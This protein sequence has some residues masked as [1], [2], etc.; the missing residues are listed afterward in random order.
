MLKKFVK[1]TVVAA[2]AAAFAGAAYAQSYVTAGGTPVRS[3]DGACWRTANWTPDAASEECDPQLVAKAPAPLLVPVVQP[4]PAAAG[5][6][7]VKPAAVKMVP[8]TYTTEVLFAFNDDRLGDDALVRLDEL[9]KQ[10]GAVDIEKI[11]AIGYAD[12]IG[13][14]HYNHLLSARRLWAVRDYLAKKGITEEQMTLQAKGDS[15]PVVS[16]GCKFMWVEPGSSRE[17]I[18]CM[19]PDRRVTIEVIGQMEAFD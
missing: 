11:V 9:S 7:P 8:F 16:E 1:C 14:S 13:S 17:L 6:S 5:A 3:A 15:D 19:E 18:A 10:L 12:V 2:V 4:G